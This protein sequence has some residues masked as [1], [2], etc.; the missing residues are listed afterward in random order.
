MLRS[1]TMFRMTHNTTSVMHPLIK[2]E[3]SLF[4]LPKYRKFAYVV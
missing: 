1:F 2:N 3:H 4:L